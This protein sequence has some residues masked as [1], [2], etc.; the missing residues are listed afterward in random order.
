MIAVNKLN[1]SINNRAIVNDVSFHFKPGMFYAVAGP[2]GSGKSSL[3]KCLC[4][5]EENHKGEVLLLGKELKSYPNRLRAQ[6]QTYVPQQSHTG[7]DFTV[8]EYI[9]M[10]RYPYQNQFATSTD[11]DKQLCIQS[12]QMTDTNHLQGQSVQTLSGGEYQRVVIARALMQ[13]TPLLYLDEPLSQLDLYHQGEMLKLFKD[14]C[15]TQQKTII[16]VLHDFNQI[17]SYT[18]HVLIM[19]QGRL[20]KHGDPH[21]TLTPELIEKIY[22]IKTQWVTPSDGTT[23]GLLPITPQQESSIAFQKALLSIEVNE[24]IKQVNIPST[25]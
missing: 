3:L 14:L 5:I 21:Q 13:D 12:M 2:N 20:I 9:M 24:W 15:D 22:K 8:K 7:F 17:L 10:G 11:N 4:G 19:H 25:H 1:F 16:C 18:D 6:Q 23:K